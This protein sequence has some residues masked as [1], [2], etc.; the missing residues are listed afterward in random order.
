MYLKWKALW[1]QPQPHFQT[2]LHIV[3]SLRIEETKGG[4]SNVCQHLSIKKQ[5]IFKSKFLNF[6]VQLRK[7]NVGV[8]QK[9]KNNWQSTCMLP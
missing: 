1:K 8:F 4:K 6:L 3:F 9:K 2:G 7:I 5:L